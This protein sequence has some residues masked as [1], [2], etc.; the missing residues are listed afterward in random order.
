MVSL[1]RLGT[2]VAWSIRVHVILVF[3]LLLALI[4]SGH[5]VCGTL[6]QARRYPTA[7]QKLDVALA[8]RCTCVVCCVVAGVRHVIRWWVLG[9]IHDLFGVPMSA[10]SGYLGQLGWTV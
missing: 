5:T 7:A 10:P 8:A 9:H 1:V 2:C 4:Y 6:V 3:V